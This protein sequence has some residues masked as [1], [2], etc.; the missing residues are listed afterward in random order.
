M[1]LDV[2]LLERCPHF[3]GWYVQAS[4]ELGPEDV[5]LLERCPHFRGWYIHAYVYSATFYFRLHPSNLYVTSWLQYICRGVPSPSIQYLDYETG[6]KRWIS[7]HYSTIS[8]LHTCVWSYSSRCRDLPDQQTVA[9]KEVVQRSHQIITVRELSLSPT[10][11]AIIIIVGPC[12]LC[13]LIKRIV[14]KLW[15]L[16]CMLLEWTSLWPLNTYK[17]LF[18]FI[19]EFP[20]RKK[21]TSYLA[22]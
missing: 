1:E 9:T 6:R 3:R 12:V 16:H 19:L 11:K 15:Q 14:A 22:T 18:F 13:N 5:S 17:V 4:V 21:C 7:I 2:S 10:H 8:C 20:T